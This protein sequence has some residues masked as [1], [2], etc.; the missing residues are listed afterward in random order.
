[1]HIY[2]VNGAPGAGKTTFEQYVQEIIGEDEVLNK[3]DIK[4]E[5]SEEVE[6]KPKKR[7]A[8]A[9]KEEK[10]EEVKEEVE[11]PKKEEKEVKEEKKPA[12]K[13]TKKKEEPKEDFDSLTVADLKAKAKEKGISGYSTMKKAE[14]VKALSK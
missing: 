1:M 11:E 14:L 2:I 10:V 3:E 5:V 4:V 8:K 13:A 7:V 9:K 12:K 6:E